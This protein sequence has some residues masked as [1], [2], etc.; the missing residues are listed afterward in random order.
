MKKIRLGGGG[1]DDGDIA[2]SKSESK[3]KP[4]ELTKTQKLALVDAFRSLGDSNSATSNKLWNQIIDSIP[5][6]KIPTFCSR[7]SINV[8]MPTSPSWSLV[9]VPAC[10]LVNIA[11]FLGLNE[12]HRFETS[13]RY[14]RVQSKFNGIWT[15]LNIAQTRLCARI[16]NFP[17]ELYGSRIY[18]LETLRMQN[19]NNS[20]P[21]MEQFMFPARLLNLKKLVH[22]FLKLPLGISSNGFLDLFMYIKNA[23]S[24]TLK[25]LNIKSSY[26][27]DKFSL[28][29]ITWWQSFQKLERVYS[30][31]ACWNLFLNLDKFPT[32]K[33]IK[34]LFMTPHDDSMIGFKFQLHPNI[35]HVNLCYFSNQLDM[36]DPSQWKGLKTLKLKSCNLVTENWKSISQIPSL[37]YLFVKLNMNYKQ[38]GNP[39]MKEQ[40]V[41]LSAIRRILDLPSIKKVN[42]SIWDIV[43][44][45]EALMITEIDKSGSGTGSG[46]GSGTFN[47]D[48]TTPDCSDKKTRN[49]IQTRLLLPKFYLTFKNLWTYSVIETTP[50]I[51][52]KSQIES[53]QFMQEHVTQYGLAKFFPEIVFLKCTFPDSNEKLK[54]LGNLSRLKTIHLYEYSEDNKSINVWNGLVKYLPHVHHLKLN[55]KGH[56]ISNIPSQFAK[57]MKKL[58]KIS[59][60]GHSYKVINRSNLHKV[61]VQRPDIKWSFGSMYF[62]DATTHHPTNEPP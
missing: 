60:P 34:M 11:A 41:P 5:S 13:C 58:K 8:I 52:S 47:I 32:M 33:R 37:E 4:L 26:T 62:A 45:S 56:S 38:N 36:I 23:C 29:S 14:L 55:L 57:K 42:L 6:E 43:N 28:L 44:D 21:G 51:T 20:S 48:P 49:S 40:E 46:S 59:F 17:L 10:C 18:N 3:S 39:D 19:T 61:T 7:F 50:S 30:D 1:G 53:K 27:N 22:L 24:K 2:E 12:Y 16:S 15:T 35:Q 31:T 9:T 25:T 54:P